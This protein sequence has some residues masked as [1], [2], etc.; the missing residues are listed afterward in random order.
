MCND[1]NYCTK[2]RA[3]KYK[4]FVADAVSSETTADQFGT[5]RFTCV[6]SCGSDYT[7]ATV[8]PSSAASSTAPTDGLGIVK[9]RTLITVEKAK[10]K[11]E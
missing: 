6:S 8:P 10:E 2:C 1:S 5:I 4:K 7:F 11:R 9:S 3:G